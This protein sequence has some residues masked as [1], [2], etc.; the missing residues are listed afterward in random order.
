MSELQDLGPVEELQRCQDVGYCSKECQKKG[1]KKHKVLCQAIQAM[2]KA[3]PE[4][5]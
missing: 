3:M 4:S 5:E 1:W 2:E